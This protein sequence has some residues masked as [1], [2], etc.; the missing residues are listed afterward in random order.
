MSKYSEQMESQYINTE[1]IRKA[2]KS[3]IQSGVDIAFK[4]FHDVN[5]IEKLKRRIMK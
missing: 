5:S 2:T 4:E 3:A 1:K